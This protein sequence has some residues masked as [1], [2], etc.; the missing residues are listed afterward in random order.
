MTLLFDASAIYSVILRFEEKCYAKFHGNFSISLVFYELGN[1]PW[2]HLARGNISQK[3]ASDILAIVEKLPIVLSVV[4]LDVKDVMGIFLMATSNAITFY[5][6]SYLFYAKKQG[7][8]LV[9]DDE[10][11]GKKASKLVTVHTSRSLP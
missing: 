1:I 4:P 8:E 3:D 7:L 11:L 9:T 2:K 5:D 6:A 10:R